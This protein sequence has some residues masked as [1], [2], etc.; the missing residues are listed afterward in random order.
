MING[1]T[2]VLNLPSVALPTN[3]IPLLGNMQLP[4]IDLP[5][6][7]GNKQDACVKD[8]NGNQVG[9]CNGGLVINDS[10]TIGL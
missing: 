7:M 5:G 1:V 8:G 3:I 6:L 2:S 9:L 10:E 4:Q